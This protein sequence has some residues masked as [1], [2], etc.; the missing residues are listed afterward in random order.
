MCGGLVDSWRNGFLIA[1]V[2]K[3]VRYFGELERK[4]GRRS[5]NHP[6]DCLITRAVRSERVLMTLRISVDCDGM[7]NH[8]TKPLIPSDNDELTFFE[9]VIAVPTTSM[10]T[11]ASRNKPLTTFDRIFYRPDRQPSISQMSSI[12]SRSSLGRHPNEKPTPSFP[13]VDE[14]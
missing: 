11:F 8:L 12:P 9:F 4:L 13:F 1:K 3:P 7:R 6:A 14:Q 10:L 5:I 2:M